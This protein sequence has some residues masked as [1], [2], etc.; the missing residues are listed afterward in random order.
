MRGRWS[1]SWFGRWFG[2]WFARVVDRT[3][4]RRLVVRIWTHGVLLF[5][6]V[7]A[8]T[9]I[10]RCSM[11]GFNTGSTLREHPELAAAV[12][13]RI[14]ARADAGAATWQ[15]ELR[16]VT[17]EMPLELTILSAR[18]G[19]VL[20]STSEVPL[21]AP[22][23]ATATSWTHRILVVTG[24][25]TTALVRVAAP[26]SLPLH[27]V[28]LHIAAFILAFVFVAGPLARSIARPLEN[29]RGLAIEL[30][31]GNLSV[32]ANSTRRD[33]I[34][35]LSRAFDTMAEQ[36]HKLRA[37]ER[38]LLGDVSHEL[39]T[40]LSRMRVVLELAR[41]ADADVGRV[42]RY[43]GEVTTDLVELES[44]VDDIIMSSRLDAADDPHA[45]RWNEARPP[46]RKSRVAVTTLV[47]AAVTRFHERWPDRHVEVH[48]HDGSPTE[49][50]TVDGDPAMLRR[51]L[52]NLLDN[53][54]KYSPDD[55][56]VTVEVVRNDEGV[57]I[58]V[59]DHG[60]GIPVED[61]D[62]V[63]T[64]FYRADPSRTR[65]SG[66][67]GLGLTLARRIVDAHA[68]SIG[69]DSAASS[70]SRFW[71]QLAVHD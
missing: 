48:T 6:G 33:E 56:P 69:F 5:A 8:M 61:H 10:A 47:D 41:D 12:A 58:E 40:P 28:L 14:V 54:C 59:R 4:G 23:G 31:N 55:T 22:P 65:A 68:G 26:P 62:R 29:L 25:T 52:D 2:R 42:H 20:A 18:D 45:A 11:S 51:V 16:H 21:Y 63:F 7:I 36:I 27:L 53:A 9:F 32:R 44:L 46:L 17:D 34:G 43:L 39:R 50:G 70:G 38:Q 71:F 3:I 19:H 15:D 24:Q 30:G 1:G 64:A 13:E 37:A 66:G 60:A 57:R 67:V 35:D 49:L